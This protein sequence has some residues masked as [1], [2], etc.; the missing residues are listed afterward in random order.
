MLNGDAI[1]AGIIPCETNPAS[2]GL[3]RTTKEFHAPAT[4]TVGSQKGNKRHVC[5]D[6]ANKHH[7]AQ[8]RVDGIQWN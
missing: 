3:S 6:C 5:K 7:G 8:K 4:L 2:G 1:K